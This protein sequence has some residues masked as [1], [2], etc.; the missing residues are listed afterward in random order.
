MKTNLGK[1]G[2]L[3]NRKRGSVPDKYVW[4][5][6]QSVNE[7]VDYTSRNAPDDSHNAGM[8]AAASSEAQAFLGEQKC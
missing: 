6:I 8:W 3:E 7:A 2:K 4:Q 1:V 5:L